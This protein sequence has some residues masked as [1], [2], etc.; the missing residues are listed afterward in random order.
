MT[1]RRRPCPPTGLSPWARATWRALLEVHH[2]EHY[3]QLTLHRAL[4]WWDRSD[5]WLVESETA[6]GRER[7]QLV[8]QSMDSANTALRHWRLLK[9]AS[10]TAVPTRPGRPSGFDW[11]AA[12]K[13]KATDLRGRPVA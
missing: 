2:F 6:T 9:F 10:P 13:V 11:S 8:K 12:R 5:R 7:G 3:E 1:D 4:A